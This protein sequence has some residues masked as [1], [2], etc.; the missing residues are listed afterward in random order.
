MERPDLPILTR[1]GAMNRA[2]EGAAP[3]APRIGLRLGFNRFRRS[4]TL[5][6]G[7]GSW[8]AT[9]SKNRTRIGAMNRGESPHPVPHAR[10]HPLPPA[11]RSG[12]RGSWEWSVHG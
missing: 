12:G 1:I 3:S 11:L 8:V 4:G 10:N 6:G 9:F 2:M 7:F 5:Q